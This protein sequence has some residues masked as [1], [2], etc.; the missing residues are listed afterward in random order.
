MSKLETMLQV[1]RTFGVRDGMLRLEYELQRGSGLMSWRMRS[2]QGWD[3]WDLNRI[4]PGTSAEEMRAKRRD[5]TRPFFFDDAQ[6]LGTSIRKLIGLDGE[7]SV[8][9]EAERILRGDLPF[10]GRLS[11]K[12]GFPPRWFQNPV[13]GQTVSPHQP[14]TQLRFASPA[15]GDMKF[16]LEPSRFLFVYPLVRA[17]A[18]SGDERFPQAF[19]N[20]M[21]DWAQC[22]PPMAGPLWICGQECSC[23]FSHGRSRCTRSSI[24]APQPA[25]VS[26]CSCQ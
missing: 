17:Y 14:W 6:T 12:S 9:A 7:K 4:A 24:R 5:G 19:W 2:V 13:T 26:H 16:I 20:T 1:G 11:F 23:A 21:E 18:L 22:S 15:H 25:S 8:L 10:F 3:S